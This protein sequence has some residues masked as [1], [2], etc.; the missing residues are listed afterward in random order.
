MKTKIDY[1][2]EPIPSF[3]LPLPDMVVEKLVK[4]TEERLCPRKNKGK[5]AA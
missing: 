2:F 3:L 4:D 1:T 5:K